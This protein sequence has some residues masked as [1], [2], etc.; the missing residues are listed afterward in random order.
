MKI[1]EFKNMDEMF[2][3][4]HLHIEDDTMYYAFLN[5]LRDSGQTNMF[6]A[7]P[8]L[9]EAFD[10]NKSEAKRILIEWIKK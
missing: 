7:A 9:M 8:Y 10:L 5:D 1:Q 2:N 3:D 6:G 4:K